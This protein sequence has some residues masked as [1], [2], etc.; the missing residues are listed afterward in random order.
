MK[1][2][3]MRCTS[4]GS[5]HAFQN[6]DLDTCR[7]KVCER[8][9]IK[10]TVVSSEGHIEAPPMPDRERVALTQR[11]VGQARRIL[12]DAFGTGKE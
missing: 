7:L 6:Q 10:L 9:N 3:K 2:V 11:Q 5:T 8:C 12:V 1:V 4:C